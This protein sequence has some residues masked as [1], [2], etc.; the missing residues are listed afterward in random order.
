MSMT[1]IRPLS[2]PRKICL[3]PHGDDTPGCS[4][5]AVWT[6]PRQM[7]TTRS[8]GPRCLCSGEPGSGEPVLST[9]ARLGTLSI[10]QAEQRRA[11]STG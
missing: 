8:G 9:V 3:R 5:M 2:F 7:G 11:R 10:P 6:T 1:S 4:A